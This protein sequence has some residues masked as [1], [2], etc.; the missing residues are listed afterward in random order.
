M[1]RGFV[2]LL[3][4]FL[5]ACHAGTSERESR[6]TGAGISVTT[7]RP[8]GTKRRDGK[9]IEQ[10]WVTPGAFRMGTDQLSFDRMI[11][12]HPPKWV[13]NE[14]PS[15]MPDHNVLIGK[16]YWID[17]TEATNAAFDAFVKAGVTTIRL[18]GRSKVGNG[19]R[20]RQRCLTIVCRSCPIILGFA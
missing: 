18:G 11:A 6:G 20:A 16:G 13:A 15:E 7:A 17:R 8:S 4:V 19:V 2:C 14:L 10:V 12:L 1:K 9:D 5:E 3:L